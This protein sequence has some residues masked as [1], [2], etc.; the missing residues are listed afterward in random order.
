M[1]FV[2]SSY[3]PALVLS[4]LLVGCAPTERAVD[5]QATM[6]DLAT[7]YVKLALSLERH[8]PGYVDAYFGPPAWPAQA[9]SAPRDLPTLGAEARAMHV[10]LAELNASDLDAIGQLRLRFLE[11]QCKAMVARI[12]ILSGH[13]LRFDEESQALYDA[14]APHYDTSHFDS[15]LAELDALLP[16]VG[17]LAERRNRFRDRFIIPADKLDAVFRAALTEARQ[18]VQP[19]LSLPSNE[20]F[21]LEYVTDKPWSGYNWFKGNAQSLIQINT[22]LPIYIDR[23]VDLA[24][25]EGYPGHHVYNTL[26]EQKLYRERGWVEHSIFPLLTPVA[27]V[28]EGSANYGIEMAF[29]RHERVAFER[30]ELFPLAGLDPNE[31][32]RYYQIE[33]IIRKLQFAGNE[34]ARRYLDG[35][36]GSEE[37]V[38]WLQDY[39]L[40]SEERARQRMRFIDTYRSYVINYNLGLEM[41][42]SYVELGNPDTAERWRRFIDLLSTPRVAS[43]LQVP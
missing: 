6:N 3:A 30:Q 19:Y 10:E 26:L 8:D 14:V 35:E 33:E 15:V 31:A 22:D 13:S 41:V 17:S 32:E 38:R 7:R 25:H 20:N 4:L 39:S 2:T 29:P 11:R 1:S 42:R 28:A 34:A 43:S 37:A 16:G 21:Q 36:I 27:L 5:P 40:M 23:A 18:R 24:C 9:D 12:D